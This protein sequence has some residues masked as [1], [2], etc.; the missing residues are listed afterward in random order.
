MLQKLCRKNVYGVNHL[1]SRIHVALLP[2]I[3]QQIRTHAGFQ[4][5]H[6]KEIATC[7]QVSTEEE[8]RAGEETSELRF[9]FF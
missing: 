6:E 2:V 4:K 5:I 7:A 8:A 1:N 3:A 9:T